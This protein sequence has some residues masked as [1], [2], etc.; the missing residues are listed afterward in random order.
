AFPW[1]QHAGPALRAARAAV[2]ATVTP[3]DGAFGFAAGPHRDPT[4][5]ALAGLAKTAGWEWPEVACKAIDLE[6]ELDAVAAAVTIADELFQAGPGEVGIG[7]QGRVA[8]ELSPAPL[9]D[10]APPPFGS[11]DVIVITG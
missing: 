3:L 5:G 4:A 8:L 1:L 7:R 10:G 11:D 2:F 9:A 6:P